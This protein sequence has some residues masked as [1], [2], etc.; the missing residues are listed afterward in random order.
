M[1]KVDGILLLAIVLLTA[2][3]LFMIYNAS[4]VI[5]QRDFQ[6]KYYYIKEQS[7]WMLLGYCGLGFFTLFSYKKLYSFAVPLLVTSI[8]LLLLVFIPGFG[9]KALGAHRWIN[10]HFFVLQP[11]EFV[12]LSLA[13]YL[14]AWFS[15]K[16]KGRLPAFLLLMGTVWLLVMLQPDMGTASI[17]LFEAAVVYFLSGGAIGHFLLLAP[18]VAIIGFLFIKSAPYRAARLTSFLNVDPTLSNVSYHTKQILIALGSGG[19]LGVGI[20]NSLQKYAYLPENVTDSIFAIIAE[21]TG[22][23]G[24]TAVVLLFTIVVWRGFVIASLAKDPFGKLFAAGITTFL[25][26]QIIINLFSMTALMPL[27]GVPLPFISYGGS[28]LIIDLAAIGILL[29]ISHTSKT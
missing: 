19:I 8:I 6:D 21:E 5:A 24:S 4:S 7:V 25:G 23:I 16:E 10:F 11:S 2:F 28:A 26:I 12:K 18:V 20:G 27:T 29:N 1:K 9:I 3:G 14:A 13:I 15:S 17:I 22:F